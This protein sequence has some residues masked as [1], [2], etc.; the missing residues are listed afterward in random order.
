MNK[1][2]KTL[3]SKRRQRRIIGPIPNLVHATTYAN[4]CWAPEKSNYNETPDLKG[5]R[6]R[7]MSGKICPSRLV[8]SVLKIHTTPKHT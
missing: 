2:T 1:R 7:L 3:Q 6:N 5:I 4:F 8:A